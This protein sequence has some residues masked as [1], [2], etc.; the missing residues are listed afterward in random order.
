MNKKDIKQAYGCINAPSELKERIKISCTESRMTRITPSNGSK[1]LRRVIP[2]IAAAAVIVI[3][4]IGV[5]L[6]SSEEEMIISTD[7]EAE[8]VVDSSEL[9]LP[10]TSVSEA[11]STVQTETEGVVP[12]KENDGV[13]DSIGNTVLVSINVVDKD[14]NGI[15]NLQVVYMP[16]DTSEELNAS[17]KG[18]NTGGI[19]IT[20]G[21][22]VQRSIACGNYIF[23]V[24]D[25]MANDTGTSSLRNAMDFN[26]TI[27]ENTAEIELVWEHP[28]PAE[29][30]AEDDSNYIITLFDDNRGY[31]EG[32]NVILTPVVYP[33]NY[34]DGFT[35]VFGGYVLSRTDKEGRAYWHCPI[36]GVYTVTAYKDEL[37]AP[38][39]PHENSFI[40][41]DDNFITVEEGKS[42]EIVLHMAEETEL[43]YSEKLELAKINVFCWMLKDT[44]SRISEGF[45]HSEPGHKGIDITT[46]GG[47]N[48][49]YAAKGG[50][51]IHSGINE[52]EPEYGIYIEIYHGNGLSTLYAHCTEADVKPGEHVEKGQLIG[53]TGSTG[54]AYGDQ[55][56]FEVKLDGE[57][58][59]P[60]DFEYEN[61]IEPTNSTGN[62][63]TLNEIERLSEEK[64]EELTWSDF[65]KYDSKEIGSGLYILRYETDDSSYSLMIGGTALEE[66]PWYIRLYDSKT[67][68]YVD[69]RTG[70]V[71]DFLTSHRNVQN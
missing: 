22:P 4:G 57:Y 46:E 34:P 10:F 1:A 20:D 3:A 23:S 64:G 26:V 48:G 9:T 33:Y 52:D 45:D 54:Y 37:S 35:D 27:D 55:L 5:T 12:E 8:S 31:L 38:D 6:R 14:G 53:K 60:L 58:L 49:I 51:V 30:N 67:D 41:P 71:R 59:D 11:E 21:N 47:L 28:T 62:V 24:F 19:R 17:S 16:E 36:S 7:N 13:T 44:V 29:L 61:R 25:R 39:I 43:S 32:Y 50:L 70:N 68:E 69:I 40:F 42:D 65:E 2:V 63:I 66:K 56:H 15:P 18:G